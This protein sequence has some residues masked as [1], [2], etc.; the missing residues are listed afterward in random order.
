MLRPAS[1]DPDVLNERKEQDKVFA[2][3]FTLN[4]GYSD[5][6]KH[7]LR[8]EKLPSLEELCA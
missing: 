5:L 7:I 3:L 4:P 2:L 8:S 1:L 6:I